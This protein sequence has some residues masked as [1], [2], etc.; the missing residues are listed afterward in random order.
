[1]A[2]VKDGKANRLRSVVESERG[3]AIVDRHEEVGSP[4]PTYAGANGSQSY[5]G[6]G[7]FKCKDQ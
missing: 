6:F 2:T 3:N 7:I 4:S 1:M 5:P